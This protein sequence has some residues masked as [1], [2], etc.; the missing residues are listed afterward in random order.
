MT[1]SSASKWNA[2]YAYS[3]S[4][5]PAP[6]GVL[7]R[8][9]HW[10][11]LLEAASNNEREDRPCALDLACGR[12]GNAHFLAEQGFQVTAWDISDTVISEIKSRNPSALIEASV[13]DVVAM[14]P[15][16]ESFDLIVVSRF[17]DRA[18]CP[19]IARALRPKGLLFYQTFVHGLDNPDYLLRP[20]EL[21]QLFKQLHIVEYHE[22]DMDSRG[23]AQARLV[24]RRPF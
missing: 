19:A 13:R 15:V 16:P 2:R 11:K 23:K 7:S 18:L 12:A 14:P 20:N 5:I 6:A 24:A 10:K 1:E 21:L 4:G 3:G 22:P 9:T 17:L 8:S